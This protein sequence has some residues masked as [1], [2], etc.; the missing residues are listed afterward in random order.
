MIRNDLKKAII[1]KYFIITIVVLVIIMIVDTFIVYGQSNIEGDFSVEMVKYTFRETRDPYFFC[2]ETERAVMGFYLFAFIAAFAILKLCGDESE[3]NYMSISVTRA[4]FF[5]YIVSKF[6]AV[7]I[8]GM[9]TIFAAYVVS[10]L[11]VH[12]LYGMPLNYDF[13]ISYLRDSEL[14]GTRVYELIAEGK[15]NIVV[16]ILLLKKSVYIGV[17]SVVTLTVSTYLK[18]RSMAIYVTA[19][20]IIVYDCITQLLPRK[21]TLC[22]SEQYLFTGDGLKRLPYSGCILHISIMLGFS[23]LIFFI[24]AYGVHR[25]LRNG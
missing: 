6:L 19:A 24:Y 9:I 18:N 14:Y 16:L 4:G 17:W 25:R 5:K 7:Y 1:S 20:V 13:S 3:S 12:F 15:G 21:L 23:I 10:I 8:T 2:L 11:V 22:L